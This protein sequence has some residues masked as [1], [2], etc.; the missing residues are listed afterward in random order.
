MARGNSPDAQT[1][2]RCRFQVAATQEK[3]RRHRQKYGYVRPVISATSR[4]YRLVAV[5]ETLFWSKSWKTV[6]DFLFHYV[7]HVLG[8][9]WA[10]NE[11]RTKPLGE[12]H[13]ILQLYDSA[14]RFQK[15]HEG[16]RTNEGLFHADLDG[17]VAA[18]RQLAYDLYV[19][20]D[21]LKLQESLVA[22]LKNRD[23]FQ[24]ARY[25]LTVAT[26]CIRAGF[27]I[28][29]EDETDASRKHPEFIA[30]HNDT[31]QVVAVEAKSRHRPGVLGFPGERQEDPKAGV[32][33]LLV[34]ALEKFSGL[35]YAV[36]VDLNLPPTEEDDINEVAWLHELTE[37]IQR[38][39]GGEGE[40]HPYNLLMFTNYPEH[41]GAEGGGKPGSDRVSVMSRS[42]RVPVEHPQA[43][44]ALH[45]AALQYG[46]I[47]NFF[48]DEPLT[49]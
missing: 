3:E 8:G 43:L 24:G 21:H 4:G 26:H 2:E 30:T 10:T 25:E 17:P 45:D 37:E 7:K 34:K 16:T 44:K 47:P 42:P 31:G 32:R 22:R 49:K 38:L 23:Q 18:Y 15:R 33:H 14:R 6:T 13:P 5:G 27:G 1:L 29:H 36:F 35:P 48:E 28:V 46:R 39:P 11:I 20:G 9:E 40:S 41:Y 19:L 12:R